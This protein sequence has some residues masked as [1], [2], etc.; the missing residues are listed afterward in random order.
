M[1]TCGVSLVFF[2]AAASDSDSESELE[3]ASDS[4]SRCA[5]RL[6]GQTRRLRPLGVMV[7]EGHLVS[8]PPFCVSPCNMTQGQAESE[9]IVLVAFTGHRPMLGPRDKWHV[10]PADRHSLVDSQ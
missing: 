10:V 3:P 5:A 2:L 1:M 6:L 4:D 8:T 7:S 9:G